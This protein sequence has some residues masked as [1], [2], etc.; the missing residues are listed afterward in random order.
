M[1]E[2]MTIKRLYEQLISEQIK[3]YES[4]GNEEVAN[5]GREAVKE[6]VSYLK[7]NSSS[8]RDPVLLLTIGG[9]SRD[10]F[11]EIEQMLLAKFSRGEGK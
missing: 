8:S 6:Y 3:H 2:G 1:M 10:K 9:T 11:G 7:A 4:T 5:R